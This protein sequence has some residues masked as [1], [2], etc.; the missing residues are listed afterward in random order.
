MATVEI[1]GAEFELIH[2]NLMEVLDLI[3]GERLYWKPFESESFIRVYSCGELISH[4]GGSMEY[5]F[6]GITSNFWE[7]PFEWIT[8]EVL[9]DARAIK[10]YLEETAR[11]RQVAF[12]RLTDEDMPKKVYFPDASETTIGEIL[13]TTLAHASHHRGQVYA[14]VHLF[15]GARLPATGTRGYRVRE[16]VDG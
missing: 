16:K 13:L 4:I 10:G 8:R 2:N 11:V 7:E 3:P 14:Y 9:P 15:S 12:S 1:I 6:N 5:A